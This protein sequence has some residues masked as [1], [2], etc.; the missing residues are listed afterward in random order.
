MLM[1][2]KPVAVQAGTTV[3]ATVSSRYSMQG[4]YQV[5]ISGTGVKGQVVPQ[6]PKKDDA[7]Q[8]PAV[9]KLKIKLAAAAE[10]MPGIRDVRVAT[11]Q[12]V[13]TVAQLLVVRDPVIVE[14]G[15][16]DTPA[17][18]QQIVLPAAVCG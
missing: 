13:S 3:E 9:E 6:E 15:S 11:P 2:L 4:A 10:A 7:A 14:A 16:N 1:S 5:L 12:G 8:K 17:Q 18:A